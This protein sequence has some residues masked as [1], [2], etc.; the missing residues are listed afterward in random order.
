MS[1]Y[2][3]GKV[4]KK[5]RKMSHEKKRLEIQTA[6]SKHLKVLTILEDAIPSIWHLWQLT[7]NLTC[8]GVYLLD[9][10]GSYQMT[11]SVRLTCMK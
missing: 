2:R 5:G 9:P 7:N 6:T 11:S 10:I 8:L 4:M 3:K 1:R